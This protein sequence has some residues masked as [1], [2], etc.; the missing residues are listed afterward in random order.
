MFFCILWRACAQENVLNC[1]FDGLKLNYLFEQIS[2]WFVLQDLESCLE[3][4]EKRQTSHSLTLS[5]PWIRD[6]SQRELF[7]VFFQ[8]LIDS[9]GVFFILYPSVDLLKICSF[10]WLGPNY[11]VHD[12]L[13]RL[14][15]EG[16]SVGCITETECLHE[17]Q[18]LTGGPT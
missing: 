3:I 9:S 2:K 8:N 13:H 10:S 5:I 16:F 17:M 12:A 15:H 1:T 7:F 4:K 14:R 18:A 11:L 6:P